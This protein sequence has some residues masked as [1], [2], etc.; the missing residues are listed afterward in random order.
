MFSSVFP[1]AA[2]LAIVVNLIILYSG[3]LK[4]RLVYQRALARR[5][6]SIGAWSLAFEMLTVFSVITNC[7]LLAMNKPLRAQAAKYTDAQWILIC[8]GAEHLILF[9]Q[10]CL[11]KIWPRI[12]YAVKI[13][14]ARYEFMSRQAYKREVIEKMS[15]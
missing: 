7:T 8:V 10:H 15:K 11:R 4:R 13:S 2:A 9:L 12:P 1:L 3:L 14:L 6:S 5:V